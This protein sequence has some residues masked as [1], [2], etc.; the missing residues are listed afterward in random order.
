MADEDDDYDETFED[1]SDNDFREDGDAASSARVRA[2]RGLMPFS[3]FSSSDLSFCVPC[4]LQGEPCSP[5]GYVL[6]A[7]ARGK[8]GGNA[9]AGQPRQEEDAGAQNQASTGGEQHGI[10]TCSRHG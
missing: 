6:G 5:E 10:I 7:G 2:L 9:G 8:D 3:S 1:D 4:C